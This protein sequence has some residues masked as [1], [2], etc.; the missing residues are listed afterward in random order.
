[1]PDI[2]KNATDTIKAFG[3]IGIQLAMNQFNKK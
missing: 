3:T 1:M 2:L